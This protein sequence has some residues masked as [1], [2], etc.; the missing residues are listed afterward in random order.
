MY[1][2]G[3]DQSY[4]SSGLVLV[5]SR[6]SIIN[7]NVV[8]TLKVDGDYFSRAKQA[9]EDIASY[10]E[11][12]GVDLEV[13]IEGL[14]FSLRGHTLQNLAGLQFMIINAIRES[15]KNVTVFTPSTVKKFAT[16]SGKAKKDDMWDCLPDKVKK[17]F[18]GI[19]KSHG[20]EDLCDAYW[21]S[22]KTK[23]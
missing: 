20:R 16:G 18:E 15:G 3:I 21:I 7:Y 22:M 6:G 23:G 4:T 1:Y 8:S 19:P 17:M 13:G 14:A 12:L 9:S 11:S 2:L 5:D 10:V